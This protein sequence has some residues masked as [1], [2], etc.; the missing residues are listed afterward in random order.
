[1]A[2]NFVQDGEALSLVAPYQVASGAGMLVGSIFAVA[3]AAAASG[4]AVQARR[5]GVWDLAKATGQAWTQGLKVYWDN[6]NKN[7]TSTASGNTLIGAAT[8]AQASGDTVGRV[9]LT[10]QLV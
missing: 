4:A 2:G 3:L 7:V 5:R 8:Q 10:G 6:T 1:M 9:V